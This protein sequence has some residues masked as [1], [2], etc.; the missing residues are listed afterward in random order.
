MQ[1]QLSALLPPLISRLSLYLHTVQAL[2]AQ[3]LLA[4]ST[5]TPLPLYNPP[6]PRSSSELPPPILARRTLLLT[7]QTSAQLH[8]PEAA[9]LRVPSAFLCSWLWLCI[10]PPTT[11]WLAAHRTVTATALATP[12]RYWHDCIPS[13]GHSKN[14]CRVKQRMKI[15]QQHNFKLIAT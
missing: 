2:Q 12:L 15:C 10:L 4:S 7:L 13:T 9:C 8:R 11:L 3:M 14:I 1:T 6:P 5:A